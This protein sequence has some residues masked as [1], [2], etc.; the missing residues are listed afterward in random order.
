M[1]IVVV[2]SIHSV[3]NNNFPHKN[4]SSLQKLFALH[5]KEKTRLSEVFNGKK[6][7]TRGNARRFLRWSVTELNL[8][9]KYSYAVYGVFSFLADC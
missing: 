9:I 5:R 7:N 4:I 1:E 8:C 6:T 3:E 2:F